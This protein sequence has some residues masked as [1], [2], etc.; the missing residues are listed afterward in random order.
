MIKTEPITLA[1]SQGAMTFQVEQ[2]TSMRAVRMLTRLGKMFGPAFSKVQSAASGKPED[3]LGVIGELLNNLQ[4]DEAE[5]LILDLLECVHHENSQ[6]GPHVN[7]MFAGHL[8]E[9]FK[10]VGFVIKVNYSDFFSALVGLVKVTGAKH[11]AVSSILSG[12]P[13]V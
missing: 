11:S 7:T 3:Q 10:L 4:P 6:I 12:Q 1:T 9:L 8:M 13:S 5:Q 2:F